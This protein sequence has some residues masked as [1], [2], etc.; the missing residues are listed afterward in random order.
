MKH[1]IKIVILFLCA[2][3]VLNACNKKNHTPDMPDQ[4]TLI[5]FTPL[6]QDAAVK[7]LADNNLANYHQDFGVWG[8]ASQNNISNPTP[9][10][11]WN[12][13]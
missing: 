6:S 10:I 8:I 11:L 4:K 3:L 7:A 13:S 12:R 5:G 2:V 9:Y 1:T